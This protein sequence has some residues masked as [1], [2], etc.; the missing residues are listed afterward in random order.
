MTFSM[1]FSDLPVKSLFV[2]EKAESLT[3][4]SPGLRTLE[5]AGLTPPIVTGMDVRKKR[6]PYKE[7]MESMGSI[8][9]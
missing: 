4:L 1:T 7:S 2:D 9:K 6:D 3:S 5:S 8:W